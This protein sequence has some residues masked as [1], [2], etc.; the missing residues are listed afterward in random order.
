[1]H[2]QGP[3]TRRLNPFRR[4][5]LLAFDFKTVPDFRNR[6]GKV[7]LV[8]IRTG[9]ALKFKKNCPAMLIESPHCGTQIP[10]RAFPALS[11]LQRDT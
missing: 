11:R 3:E 4:D 9:L 1:M 2:K 7:R 8:R 5:A 10:V 6:R